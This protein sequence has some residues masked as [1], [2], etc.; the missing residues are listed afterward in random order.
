MNPITKVFRFFASYGLACVLLFLL[1]LLTLFGTLEQVDSGLYVVQKKYF[2]SFFLI[3]DQSFGYFSIPIPLPGAYPLMV[4]LFINLVCGAI[5]RAPKDWK[6]PGMLIAHG[7]IIYLVAAA[8]VTAEFSHSGHMT[9]FEGESSNT[10]DD[11]YLWE[12]AITE[13]NKPEGARTFT[14]LHDQFGEMKPEES[15]TFSTDDLPFS[16]ELSSFNKNVAPRL[17]APVLNEK[18]IDGIVMEALPLEKEAERNMA[19]ATATVLPKAGATEAKTGLLWAMAAA[20][21]VVEVEGKQYAIALRHRQYE[22]PFTIT[23]DKFIR[24]L[25]ARTMMASNFES[26][27]TKTDGTSSRKVNIRMNEPLRDSGFTFFQASWGPEGAKPGEPLFSTFAVVNNPADQWPKYAC[28]VIGIGMVI[29]FAQKLAGYIR[30][31]NRRRAV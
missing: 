27:V 25:H 5:I 16:L 28:Y 31:Q 11:Y 29:H 14:I 15:R 12:V 26:E 6:R 20:P 8:F 7:G 21:W 1:M 23:L 4:L 30:Q 19:G 18:G 2:E 13:L 10:F 3:H 17:A 24:E 22:V 9:L